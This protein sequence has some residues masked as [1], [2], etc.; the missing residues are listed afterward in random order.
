M[1]PD[2]IF[3][4]VNSKIHGTTVRIKINNLQAGIGLQLAQVTVG[5]GVGAA[6][7]LPLHGAGDVAFVGSCC[8]CK[9]K[10][11]NIL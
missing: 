8:S 5:D 3:L 1:T 6:D 10:K 4:E 11:K 7:W 9:L 2:D